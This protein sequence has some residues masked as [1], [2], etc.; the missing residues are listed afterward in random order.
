MAIIAIDLNMAAYM[1]NGLYIL[2][3]V[4]LVS[5]H[6]GIRMSEYLEIGDEPDE[7]TIE[8]NRTKIVRGIVDFLR[9]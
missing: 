1:I 9:P 6:F 5:R 3:L 4:S 2:F 8:E 7:S